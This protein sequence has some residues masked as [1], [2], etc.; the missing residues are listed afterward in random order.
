[1]AKDPAFLFYSSDFL[2]GTQFMDD[3]QVGKYIRLLC[4]QHQHGR[5]SSKHMLSICKTHDV[6][7]FAKFTKDENGFYYNDRL[8][9]EVV[10]RSNY[11]NSRKNNAL[12]K[13]T[14]IKNK[15]AYAKHMETETVTIN[16]TINRKENKESEIIFPF[17]SADF[18]ESWKQWKTYKKAEHK[19][20]Y[21][22]PASEQ[23]A[24]IE[25]SKMADTPEAA[26]KIIVQ[27]ISNGWKGFF[28]L[29]TSNNGKQSTGGNVDTSSAFAKIDLLYA[30]NGS[31]G[32][33]SGG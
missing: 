14:P 12:S 20:S 9:A 15:K 17:N 22:S 23:A 21:K 10:R 5:L 26:C 13:K 24:L 32:N 1:M 19:F 33:Q 29:K 30:K 25:L 3:E 7:I 6:E 11:S 28:A 31:T 2:I 27:S 16:E 8:E 18:I 4:A